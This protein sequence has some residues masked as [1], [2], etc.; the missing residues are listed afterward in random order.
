MRL[1][2]SAAAEYSGKPGDLED[3]ADFPR[4][5]PVCGSQPD[6]NSLFLCYGKDDHVLCADFHGAG[7]DAGT[8]ADSPAAVWRADHD[9]VEHGACKS[10]VSMSCP[11]VEEEGRQKRRLHTLV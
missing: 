3:Y 10:T 2:G 6:Y 11:A 5:G 9:L 4:F 8:D 1:G 7:T